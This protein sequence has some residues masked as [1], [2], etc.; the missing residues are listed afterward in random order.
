MGETFN[1]YC[2][3]SCHLENDYQQVMVL[4]A[5]WCPL[6]KTREINHR[7]R[8]IRTR[9]GL[10]A[11][12]VIGWT[13]VSPAK[14]DFYRDILDYFFDDDDLHVRVLTV[15]DK[16]RVQARLF[17]AH[18]D[19]WYYT[20]Y[21]QMLTGILEPTAHYRIY[22]DLK[23]THGIARVARLRQALYGAYKRDVIERI[24]AVRARENSLVQLTDLLIGIVAYANRQMST[25]A[26]KVALVKRMSERA[27]YDLRHSTYSLERKINLLQWRAE[28][29]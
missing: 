4:G 11:D 23:D 10:P 12:F 13:K 18:R 24:Q 1:I 7:L 6:D 2:D 25:S 3:E 16:S 26:A 17:P 22:F 19:E 20:L 5:V 28:E 9:H 27:H 15:P 14:L 21:F 8:E 29:V